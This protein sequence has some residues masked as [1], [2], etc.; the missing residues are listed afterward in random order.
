M[1]VENYFNFKYSQNK[2]KAYPNSNA[3]EQLK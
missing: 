2:V 3:I 1:F